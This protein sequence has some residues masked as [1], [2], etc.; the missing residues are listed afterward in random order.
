MKTDVHNHA[1][2]ESAMELLARDSAYGATIDRKHRISGGPEGPQTVDREFYDPAAHLANLEEHGL[3]AA[4]VSI[5]PI[6]FYYD[7]DPEAGAAMSQAVNEGLKDFCCTSPDRLHWM[8]TVP[9][10]APALAVSILESAK[11]A[12]CVGVEVGTHIV[13]KR[14]DEPEFE[15]FWSAAERLQLPV[16][17]HPSYNQPHPGL[18]PYHLQNVIGN[19]LETTLTIERLICSGV[20]DRHPRLTILIVHSGGYFAWQAGRLRHA[21]LVRPELASAPVDPWAYVGQIQFDCL[22]HDRQA[23]SYLL[24]RVGADN[25]LMGTDLPCDMATQRPWDDLCSVA[26]QETARKVTETNVARVFGVN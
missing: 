21:R 22:T 18:R 9:M 2:P 6:F 8:A 24:S 5:D 13:D 11:L 19:Q 20:L 26:D 4:V 12:G 23:L 3:E 15:P 7:A 1:V 14:L 17:I 25:V 10:Q 16:M